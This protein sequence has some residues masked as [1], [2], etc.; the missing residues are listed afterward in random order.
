MAERMTA[1]EFYVWRN[2]VMRM[3]QEEIA[4]FLFK[5]TK[6]IR[7]WESGRHEVDPMLKRVIMLGAD[8]CANAVKSPR[9]GPHRK[10]TK[11]G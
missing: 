6:T 9:R 5:D 3:T 11:N 2:D 7:Q 1:D 8:K 10:P 4:K